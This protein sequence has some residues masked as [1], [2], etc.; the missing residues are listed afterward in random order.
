MVVY[1]DRTSPSLLCE[2]PSRL[3]RGGFAFLDQVVRAW[4]TSDPLDVNI[5][6]TEFGTISGLFAPLPRISATI[7]SHSLIVFDTNEIEKAYGYKG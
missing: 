3:P 5:S 4:R 7:C 2:M 6:R 1:S